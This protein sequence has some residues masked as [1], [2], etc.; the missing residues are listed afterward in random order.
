VLLLAVVLANELVRPKQIEY[1]V[2]ALMASALI[3]SS[4]GLMQ[5]VGLNLPLERLGQ[6]QQGITEQIGLQTASRVGA[7]LGHPNMLAAYLVLIL[8]LACAVLFGQT[9]AR[10]KALSL[11]TLLIGSAALVLTLSRAAWVGYAVG[12][13]LCIGVSF[14]HPRLRY[15]A[16]PLRAIVL[17][18]LAVIGLLFSGAIVSKFTMSNPFSVEARW[19]WLRTAWQMIKANPIFGVGLNA[20]TFFFE[21]YD[22][23]RIPWD[24]KP[25]VHNIYALTWSEQGILGLLLFAGAILSIMKLGIKNL[26]CKDNFMLSVGLGLWAGLCAVLVQGLADWTLRANPVMRTFW[27]S[28]GVM[29]AIYCGNW[30]SAPASAAATDAPRPLQPASAPLPAARTEDTA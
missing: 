3:Q 11:A 25:P 6:L 12:L 17:I 24:V 2:A 29:M 7:M 14:L 21:D 26:A 1:V 22:T 4:Y 20:Y 28:I 13:A 19:Q 27:I 10:M 9:H 8:P 30:Q 16:L 5:R 15:K 18:G 23:S